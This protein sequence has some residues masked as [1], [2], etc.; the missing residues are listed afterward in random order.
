MLLSLT[1]LETFLY[2]LD[3]TILRRL[4]LLC[5]AKAQLSG[6][7][8]LS[9]SVSLHLNAIQNIFNAKYISNVTWICEGLEVF[10]CQIVGLQ[11]LNQCGHSIFS[12]IAESG[13]VEEECSKEEQSVPEEVQ[14]CKHLHE[15]VYGQLI[16]DLGYEYPH[17]SIYWKQYTVGGNE[18]RDFG[19]VIRN[20]LHLTLASGLDRLSTLKN[21]QVF[22]FEGADLPE[23]ECISEHWP[24]LRVKRGL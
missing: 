11:R 6:F 18:Y 1:S 2:L 17:I 15:A 7:H 5:L 14:A 24:M 22:E 12:Y 16:L 21:L 13:L 19:E 3:Y 4:H 8:L 10:R 9:L 20:I 23:L